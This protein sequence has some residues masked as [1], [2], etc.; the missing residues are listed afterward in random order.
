MTTYTLLEDNYEYCGQ[1]VESTVEIV[2][3]LVMQY[4][5]PKGKQVILICVGF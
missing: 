5:V 1:L 4:R 3:Y 2:R